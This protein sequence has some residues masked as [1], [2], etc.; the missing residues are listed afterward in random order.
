MIAQLRGI[1]DA[2]GV[3]YAVI[4]VGGVGYRVMASA[5][6]L[7]TLGAVGGEALIHTEM[8]VSD[9][10]IR[11]IGFASGSERDWF[12]LLSSVQGVGS[13]VALAILSALDP[14]EL[15]QAIAGGDQTMV[16][17]AQG[18][19][20]KLAQRIVNEL[21]DKAGVVPGLP[22]TAA[23]AP[24]GGTAADAI[25]ALTGLG[26]KPGEASAAVQRAM[27]AEGD[28]AGLDRIVRAALKLVAR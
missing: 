12:G 26:F 22:G 9:D 4:D 28:D 1:I 11:L 24:A 20:P 18:V 14:G 21:R 2:I 17:R 15:Q 8:L 16:S 27:E 23:R 3:D 25:S 13:K 7:S 5:R 10:A 19:G 6:S